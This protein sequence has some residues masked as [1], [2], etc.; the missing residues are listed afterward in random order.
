MADIWVHLALTATSDESSSKA[1]LFINGMEDKSQRVDGLPPP[2]TERPIIL[3][4][5]NNTGIA[6]P[7]IDWHDGYLD[8]VR[9]ETVARSSEW[10]RAGYLSMTGQLIRYEL[11]PTPVPCD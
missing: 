9:I 11:L 2:G 4:A 6:A 5:D 1:T 3:G 8:E 10:V 7:N